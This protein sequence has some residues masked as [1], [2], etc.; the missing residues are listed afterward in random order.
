LCAEDLLLP[1]GEGQEDAFL[2]TA[3]ASI[4]WVSPTYLENQITNLKME[5]LKAE[6]VAKKF[7]D[8]TAA[9]SAV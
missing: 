1:G 4:I 8:D 9:E 6:R 3:A 7:L 5:L 2:L